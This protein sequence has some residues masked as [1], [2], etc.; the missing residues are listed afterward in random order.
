MGI[1]K[2][3]NR[4]PAFFNTFFDDAFTKDLFFKDFMNEDTRVKP[5]VNVKE[6]ENSFQI[7]LIAPGFSKED[8]HLQVHE[9]TLTLSGKHEGKKSDEQEKYTFRE[10]TF[11][12]FRRSFT[13]PESVN[14]EAIEAKY[15][16]G[17]LWVTLPKHEVVK[18]SPKSI[19]VS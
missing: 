18:A 19:K 16:N 1:V 8:L 6:T 5:A 3:R 11:N 14:E 7:E 13:L 9:G 12:S 10:F 2:Y 4:K 17:I 15:E